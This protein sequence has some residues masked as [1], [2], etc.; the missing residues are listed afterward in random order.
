MTNAV[1]K[2][3]VLVQLDIR[4]KDIYFLPTEQESLGIGEVNSKLYY[5]GDLEVLSG[6]DIPAI[7]DCNA[8]DDLISDAMV[9]G[10]KYEIKTKFKDLNDNFHDCVAIGWRNK[11]PKV[12]PFDSIGYIILDNDLE[13]KEFC[14]SQQIEMPFFI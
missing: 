3:N 6:C 1:S 9:Y 7:N 5:H 2:N 8:F 4:D 13:S 10:N 14:L 12:F 11:K